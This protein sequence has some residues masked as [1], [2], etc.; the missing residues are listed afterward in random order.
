MNFIAGNSRHSQFITVLSIVSVTVLVLLAL[1]GTS[2]SHSALA[3]EHQADQLPLTSLNIHGESDYME[4]PW[5]ITPSHTSSFL[6]DLWKDPIFDH[7]IG[8]VRGFHTHYPR[9][10]KSLQKTGYKVSGILQWSSS[11]NPGSFP[12][13]DL[14]G[15]QKYIQ[16]TIA[17]YPEIT[18][19]EV[20]NEPPNFTEDTTAESYA[21]IVESAYNTIKS[22]NPELQV[23]LAAKSVHLN[24]LAKTIAFGARNKFDFITLHPYEYLGLLENGLDASYMSITHQ[25]RTLLREI[26]PEK[27]QVPIRFTELGFYTEQPKYGMSASERQAAVLTKSMLL[28]AAQG[29]EKVHW[30]EPLDAENLKLGLLDERQVPRP[31]LSAYRQLINTLGEKPVYL[32]WNRPQANFI[33]LF[34]KN[35]TRVIMLGWGTDEKTHSLTSTDPMVDVIDFITGESRKLQERPLEITM[36]PAI[37]SYPVSNTEIYAWVKQ[38]IYNRQHQMLNSDT[39]FSSETTISLSPDI[40]N[41]LYTLSNLV[42]LVYEGEKVFDASNSHRLLLVIDPTFF[43]SATED[44]ILSMEVMAKK[45]AEHKPGFNMKFDS[46][47]DS[48][49][50]ALSNANIGWNFVEGGNFYT[51]T[52]KINNLAAVGSFGFHLQ[53]DSDNTA[54]SQYLI[55]SITIKR[56]N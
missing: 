40:K 10:L 47:T 18:H 5:G 43:H 25:T 31:A 37:I 54:S 14:P 49:Y 48:D 38:A 45:N 4:S 12:A 52:W 24:F 33:Q 16:K 39:D 30:F 23:G 17:K 36:R 28:A 22:I 26:N 8:N 41:G 20:W 21:R 51:K 19:W 7:G 35:K 56:S 55:K 44:V 15:W 29:I 1:N 11:A 6:I 42:T 32:G 50:E 9:K 34:F 53:L 27:E 46:Y 2:S 13:D 3:E